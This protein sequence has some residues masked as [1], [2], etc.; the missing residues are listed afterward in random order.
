MN[1]PNKTEVT[2]TLPLF[3]DRKTNFDAPFTR[4]MANSVSVRDAAKKITL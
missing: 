2:N 4:K 3:S 1:I